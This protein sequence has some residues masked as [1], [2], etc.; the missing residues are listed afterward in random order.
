MH[1]D[2]NCLCKLAD[3]NTFSLYGKLCEKLW[4]WGVTEKVARD[5]QDTTCSAAFRRFVFII[6]VPGYS[7]TLQRGHDSMVEFLV[8]KLSLLFIL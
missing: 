3:E 8:M 4:K 1:V 7:H 6:L 2:G 5:I